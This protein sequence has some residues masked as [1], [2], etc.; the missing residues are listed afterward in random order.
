MT[1]QSMPKRTA[2]EDRFREPT[3]EELLRSIVSPVSAELAREL[4]KRLLSFEGVSEKADW[5]GVPWRWAL[6]FSCVMDPTRA[7]AYIIPEPAKPQLSI[8]LTAAMVQSLPLKRMKKAARDGILYS[9]F[10]AGVH[11]PAWPLE[12]ASQLD[13]LFEILQRKYRSVAGEWG[14]TG[15]ASG[16]QRPGVKKPDSAR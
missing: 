6:V 3:A 15:G 7:F 5:Q 4:R 2:W 1:A 12:T 13:E 10:V 16:G 14:G 9:R 11:W 8:P